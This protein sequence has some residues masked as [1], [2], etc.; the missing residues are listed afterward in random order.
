LNVS[1]GIPIVSTSAGVQGFANIQ[2]TGIH[3]A[4]SPHE[5]AQVIYELHENYEL[6]AQS[7]KIGKDYCVK[8]LS[9]TAM[10]AAV[11]NLILNIAAQ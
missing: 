9:P 10:H 6:W 7:E 4:D 2:D 11:S 1:F 3:V 8:N 5:M